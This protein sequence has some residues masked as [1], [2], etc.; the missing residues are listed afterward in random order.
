M[1]E[2]IKQNISSKD[3]LS[4]SFK[5]VLSKKAKP[6]HKANHWGSLDSEV[7]EENIINKS[8]IGI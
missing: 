1:R 2:I 5:K 8:K 3:K 7:L 4:I 6:F